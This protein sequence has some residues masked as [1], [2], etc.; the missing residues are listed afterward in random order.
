MKSARLL[1]LTLLAACAL[2]AC[3][4]DDPVAPVDNPTPEVGLFVDVTNGDDTN[5]GSK[6]SPWKTLTHALATADENT[7]INVKPG[8]YNDTSGETFPIFMKAGQQLIG[9]VAEKGAG[10]T[11]IIIE[12]EGDY[13]IDQ[14]DGGAIVGAAGARVAGLQFTSATNPSFYGSVLVDGVDMKIDHNTFTGIYAGIISSNGAGPEVHDNIFNTR[15]YGVFMDHSAGVHVYQNEFYGPTGI[16]MH[17]GT[18]NL[19]ENN[20][21]ETDTIGFSVQGPGSPGTIQNNTFQHAGGFRFGAIDCSNGSP[22]IRGNTIK[23]GPALWVRSTGSPDM[24][25]AEDAGN[26]DLTAITDVIIQHDG[27]Q[28]ILAYGNDWP[29]EP[30]TAGEI[31]ITSTGS[32][33]TEW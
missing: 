14:L 24:G 15:T 23:N 20:L 22:V 9:D 19:L 29:T 2:S 17:N 33:E 11:P 3:S 26:N 1:I 12:G 8:T 31:V 4:E 18:D 30:P 7:T 27:T 28:T 10:T 32:V 13:S 16:R 6:A 25:T 21:V 5:D